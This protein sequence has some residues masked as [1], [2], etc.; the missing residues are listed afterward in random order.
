MAHCLTSDAAPLSTTGRGRLSVVPTVSKRPKIV[1]VACEASGDLLG[2]GLIEDLKQIYPQARFAGVGGKAMQDAG[3]EAWHDCAE[4]S[5]MGIVEVLKHLPRLLR[6]R[7]DVLAR[8]L[9]WNPDVVIGIDGPDFNL[10]LEHQL[11]ANGLRTVHYVSP[12]IWAWRERWIVKKIQRSCDLV[13]CLF[14]MEPP[15]YAR[16]R[17]PAQFV[18]HPIAEQFEME[19]KQAGARRSL[20]VT[21]D[22]PL[23]GLLPGSRISEI[24]QLGM[25]FLAA[26]VR[27]LRRHPTLRFIAP[28]A[29]ARCR[30]AF[31]RLLAGPASDPAN[32][33]PDAVTPAEWEALRDSIT[34]VDGMSHQVMVAS[35]CLLLACGTAA[36]EGMLAKRPMVVAY[37]ISPLTHFIVKRLGIVKINRYSLP[38]ILAGDSIVPEFIQDDC[39]APA[40]AAALEHHLADPGKFLAVLPTY[41]R[42]HGEL[43]QDASTS[44]ARAV[45]DLI[46]ARP[47]SVTPSVAAFRV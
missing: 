4:L 24:A 46:E 43:R 29:N 32:T 23:L 12:S 9:A 35:D 37:K 33:A 28:M 45:A 47:L 27:L 7:K 13:L 22:G 25:I 3:L 18:G 31:E 34:I 41:S 30:Q 14:P 40:I 44:A 2:A 16:Y 1:L 17:I 36:L 6:L 20:N 21:V 39:T 19:P 5:V 11:K 42:L 38:N 15:I 26:A 8:T 10:G